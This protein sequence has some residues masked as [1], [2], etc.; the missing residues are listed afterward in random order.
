LVSREQTI[1]TIDQQW[2]L[3]DMQ[4][5][6]DRLTNQARFI[7]MIIDRELVISKKK[8]AV[9][10]AELKRLNFKPFAKV[11]DATKDGEMAPIADDDAENDDDDDDVL[12]ASSSYD[13]LLGV[14][15]S[16]LQEDAT[17]HLTD[18][19]IDASMVSDT[20]ES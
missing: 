4:R 15:I 20:R 18:F 2:L 7:K 9:L 1:L 12:L 13:Y 5:E 19:P 17:P 16:L 6:L 10:I 8:K 3:A 11:E 14:C